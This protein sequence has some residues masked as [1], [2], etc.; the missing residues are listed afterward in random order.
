MLLVSSETEKGGL[1]A[2]LARDAWKNADEPGEPVAFSDVSS[3]YHP[4]QYAK[5]QERR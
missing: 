3:G 4:H 2:H 5:C 1:A